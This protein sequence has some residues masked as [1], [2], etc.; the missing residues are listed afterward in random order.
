M[1]HNLFSQ[2][3]SWFIN[4]LDFPHNW[5]NFPNCGIRWEARE[6]WSRWGLSSTWLR[7]SRGF[8]VAKR[9]NKCRMNR[10]ELWWSW[11]PSYRILL[12]LGRCS[13][14]LLSRRRM[15]QLASQDNRSEPG[16]LVCWNRFTIPVHLRFPA[17]FLSLG[18][19]LGVLH[20][21]P[22]VWVWK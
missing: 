5:S 12:L 2:I 7:T 8:V 4:Q 10:G 9:Q 19:P 14:A 18:K 21:D 16:D 13:S 3:V 15:D 11:E 20:G 6:S 22:R 1:L 17:G